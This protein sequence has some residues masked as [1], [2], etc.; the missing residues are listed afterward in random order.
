MRTR[1]VTTL[2][3]LILRQLSFCKNNISAY[4]YIDNFVYLLES[5]PAATIIIKHKEKRR[6]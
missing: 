6:M 5:C 3:L 2:S 1:T 4:I